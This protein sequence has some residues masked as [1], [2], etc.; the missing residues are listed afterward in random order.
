VTQ[1][2]KAKLC[3]GGLRTVSVH[4]AEQKDF[5]LNFLQPLAVMGID[6]L[7]ALL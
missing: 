2:Y 6:R 5:R 3:Q 1:N 7:K 4:G